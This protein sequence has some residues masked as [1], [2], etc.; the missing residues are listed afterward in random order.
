METKFNVLCWDHNADKL[1]YYD[2]L[3]YFRECYKKGKNKPSTFEE[4]KKFIK[5]KSMY[6]FWSRCQYEIICHGF[7]I[8][9][10]KYKLDVHEQI[11]MNIDII[12]D[13]LYKEFHQ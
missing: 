9:K 7:P 5:D 2:V 11:M 12:T 4:L 13:I 10:K 6:Q 8:E 3:P 1:E